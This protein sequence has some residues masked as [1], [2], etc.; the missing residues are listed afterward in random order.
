MGWIEGTTPCGSSDSSTLYSSLLG[1]RQTPIGNRACIEY[2]GVVTL[3]SSPPPTHASTRSQPPLTV[4]AATR[5]SEC[6]VH[7]TAAGRKG[8]SRDVSL[9][10]LPPCPSLPRDPAPPPPPRGVPSASRC[11][12]PRPDQPRPARDPPG[13]LAGNPPSPRCSA[14]SCSQSRDCPVLFER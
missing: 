4:S 3:T 13:V 6:V 5:F 12:A 7:C 1:H 11:V 8:A 9:S 14:L 2:V 10:L